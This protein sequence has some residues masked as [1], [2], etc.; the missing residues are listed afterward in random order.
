MKRLKRAQAWAFSRQG[1]HD[2]GAFI[3]ACVAIYKAAHAAGVL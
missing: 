3:A 2:I 1:F